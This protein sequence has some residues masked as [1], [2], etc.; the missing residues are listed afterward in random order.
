MLLLMFAAHFAWYLCLEIEA[1]RSRI[2]VDLAEFLMPAKAAAT[3]GEHTA[4]WEPLG[5]W[6]HG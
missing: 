6:Q 2:V 1:R 3:S 5:P 4:C